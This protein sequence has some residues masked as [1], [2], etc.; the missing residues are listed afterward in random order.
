MKKVFVLLAMVLM[1]GSAWAED[2]PQGEMQMPEMGPPKEMM[3]L[4]SMVGKWSVDMKSRQM[5]EQPWEESKGSVE[6]EY[7]LGG[8]AVRQYYSGDM[9]G[10]P[11]SGETTMCYNRQ[12][13]LWQVTWI[14]NMF[15]QMSYY[16]G[17]WD[18]DK[19]VASN[20]E[21]WM[22]VEYLTRMTT[23]NITDKS[24]EWKMEMSMDDGKTW[25]SSMEAVYTKQ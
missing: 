21:V 10:A 16:E 23:F 17:H 9:M 13:K 6:C 8:S 5:P 19:F 18:G 4:E 15:A 25:F 22:G 7:I 12:T 1:I 14:D 2:M 3:S 24:Y 11:F 20:R